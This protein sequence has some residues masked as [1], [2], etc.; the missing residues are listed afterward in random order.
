MHPLKN[1][2][3]IALRADSG[4]FMSRIVRGRVG[5]QTDNIEAAGVSPEP[6]S[7]S[8]F[9]VF[10]I[11][12]D[13][14]ALLADNRRFVSRVARSR[15][16]LIEAAKLSIDAYCLFK[17]VDLGSEKI[18]L[19]ADNGKFL[20]RI[21]YADI[22]TIEALA[23][24]A[25]GD[26]PSVFTI[27]RGLRTLDPPVAG[28]RDGDLI[29]LQADSGKYLSRINRGK[30]RGGNWLDPIEA[31]AESAGYGAPSAFR[32]EVHG[33]NLIG[34]RADNGR[35]VSRIAR[36]D[37]GND[38]CIE[39]A[40]A[41][42]G[43]P[44]RF[45]ISDMKNGRMAL[46]ADNG[47]FLSR[48]NYG[49]INPIEARHKS[50]KEPSQFTVAPLNFAP[51]VENLYKTIKSE[52]GSYE[53]KLFGCSTANFIG[54]SPEY[55]F[56][57]PHGYWGS[58]GL[59]DKHSERFPKAIGEIIGKA[60]RLVDISTMDGVPD[61]W[62]H[63]EIATALKKVAANKKG[64]T[65]R[66]LIGVP[67]GTSIEGPE[68]GREYLRRLRDELKDS[69]RC[70]DIWLAAHRLTHP[71]SWNHS[72]FI[73]VD[74]KYL[75]TGGHNLNHNAYMSRH[76]P[77]FDLSIRVDGPAALG[78]HAFANHLWNY[79]RVNVMRSFT[80]WSI[81]LNTNMEIVDNVAP[82]QHLTNSPTAGN[83]PVLWVT[84]PGWGVFDTP[85]NSAESAL[86]QA[87]R[88]ARHVRLSQQ[89]V[90]TNPAYAGNVR[91][92]QRIGNSYDVYAVQVEFAQDVVGATYFSWPLID[93]L[94]EL[95]IRD[96]TRLD[97]IVSNPE[98]KAE[99]GQGGSGG[100]STGSPPWAFAKA[101]AQVMSQ[102][103]KE[104]LQINLERLDN[105]LHFGTI[106]IGNSTGLSK[107]PDGTPIGNHSKFWMVDDD[108]FYVGS[109]NAY[110]W[111]GADFGFIR[112][113]DGYL[114][115]FGVIVESKAAGA[116]MLNEFFNL[117]LRYSEKV[118]LK[119]P[120]QNSIGE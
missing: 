18:A 46:K 55:L 14:V 54:G 9:T 5:E 108:L 19:I 77:I 61:G 8:E 118:P 58:P 16:A 56:D 102:K 50:D 63:R 111:T 78:A 88:N 66:I 33:K 1:G 65:V 97:V 91:G 53:G 49:D 105:R 23:E 51:T 84:T 26:S 75:I 96:G 48:I 37:I 4:K 116:M 95:M 107:W 70:L 99:G 110:P 36:P 27:L 112:L 76:Q 25:V 3:F 94:S 24:T 15:P 59:E 22:N 7:P 92:R 100:Y 86:L 72:K 17:V 31:A 93:A 57:T 87:M 12:S 82:A 44:S 40:A 42:V 2:E 73:A 90:G 6:R 30:D 69:P 89:D 103:N 81:A 119:I 113:I 104:P 79:M 52:A 114:Q 47:N 83:T 67:L 117:E 60:E 32:V 28:L 68:Y 106:G 38:F 74:G 120:Y 101:I 39:A 64:V 34:L 43:G 13:T 10:V 35:Y 115:E 21:N 45:E 20:S 29:G 85:Y 41:G 71:P 62:F 109:Q 80:F 11:D 98:A